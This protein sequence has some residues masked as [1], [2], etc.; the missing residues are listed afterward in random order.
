MSS[1]FRLFYVGTIWEQYVDSMKIQK[2]EKISDFYDEKK[3]R[4]YF[5]K[6]RILHT[7]IV[8]ELLKTQNVCARHGGCVH[9]IA[10]A[11]ATCNT[12]TETLAIV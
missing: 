6:L 12:H 9:D 8:S 7:I 11:C 3:E 1:G 2:R 4:N 5:A 10:G